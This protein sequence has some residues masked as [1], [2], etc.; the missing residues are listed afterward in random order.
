MG[1]WYNKKKIVSF[2]VSGS[3]LNFH[4]VATRIIN[5]E[6]RARVGVVVTDNSAARVLERAEELGIAAHFIDPGSYRTKEEYEEKT[7]QIFKQYKTD[8]IVTAGF[9]RLLTSYFVNRFRNQIINIHPSL[10]PSFPGIHGQEKALE[11]GV[12][13]TGCTSHFVDAGI[14]SGPIIMQSPVSILDN[15]TV[16]S[17]SARILNEEYRVLSESVRLFCEGLLHVVD[18]KVIRR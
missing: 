14:D 4:A 12:K 1:Y 17:L 8:L 15:D 7:I 2:L 16:N 6:I 13:I 10:L 9:M 5:K 18:N 3:G 11:Y